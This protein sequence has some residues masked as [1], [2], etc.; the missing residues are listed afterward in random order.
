MVEPHEGGNAAQRTGRLCARADK[1]GG[2]VAQHEEDSTNQNKTQRKIQAVPSGTAAAAIAVV[3]ANGASCRCHG[4]LLCS[5]ARLPT[6][7]S[8]PTPL[9]PFHSF[10]F[11]SSCSSCPSL[12]PPPRLPF[13]LPFPM[14]VVVSAL[15]LYINIA[16]FSLVILFIL[17]LLPRRMSRPASQSTYSR[18]TS[19][20]PS[21]FVK[22]HPADR[23]RSTT[24]P[25]GATAATLALASPLRESHHPPFLPPSPPLPPSPRP[26]SAACAPRYRHRRWCLGLPPMAWRRQQQQR[27]WRPQ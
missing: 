23:P 3:Q 16:Y 8:S 5:H 20:A 22:P 4:P 7:S 14:H 2:G 21:A 18:L 11:S 1:G 12:P 15:L 9:P 25:P 13:P 6:T 26:A 10:C 27:R 17:L 24:T 19:Q